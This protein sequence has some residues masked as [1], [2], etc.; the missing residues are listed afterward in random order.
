MC[1]GLKKNNTQPKVYFQLRHGPLYVWFLGLQD[2][3]DY[4]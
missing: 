4:V 1:L 2:D 3:C